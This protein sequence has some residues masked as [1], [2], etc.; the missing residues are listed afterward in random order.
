MTDR[1]TFA[2]AALT[3]WL[4]SQQTVI[5]EAEMAA[6]AYRYAD[7]MLRERERVTEPITQEKRA[8]VSQRQPQPILTYEER[9]AIEFAICSLGRDDYMNE[10]HAKQLQETLERLI[11]RLK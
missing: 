3:G 7:A 8:E 2:A 5:S 11:E 1:D 4:A 6:R 9:E 10:R